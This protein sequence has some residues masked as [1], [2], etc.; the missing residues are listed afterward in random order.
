MARYGSQLDDRGCT[1]ARHPRPSA[2]RALVPSLTGVLLRSAAR[3]CSLLCVALCVFCLQTGSVTEDRFITLM[4]NMRMLSR[5]DG[6]KAFL[7]LD[8]NYD[9][10]LSMRE[11][12]HGLNNN[13]N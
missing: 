13:A 10:K 9:D 11:L 3:C 7:D 4:H 2:P 1:G 5:D 6:K 8:I 12:L